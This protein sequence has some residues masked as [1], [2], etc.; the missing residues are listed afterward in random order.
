MQI[1]VIDETQQFGMI[2]VIIPDEMREL[3][4]GLDGRN[5]IEIQRLSA[6][7]SAANAC[8]ST[9]VNKLLLAAEIVI[10]HSLVGFGAASDLVDAR[11]EQPTSRKL[12]RGGEQNAAACALRISFDFWLVHGGFVFDEPRYPDSATRFP[13]LA[14]ACT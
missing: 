10:E 11:A 14:G 1:L 9:A 3:R 13:C 2:T 5:A 7:L 4:D 8:S 6:S 12:L